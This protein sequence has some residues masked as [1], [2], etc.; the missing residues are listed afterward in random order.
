MIFS[1][2]CNDHSNTDMNCN[3][4]AG[5]R[6]VCS[7]WRRREARRTLGHNVVRSLWWQT[8]LVMISHIRPL[9]KCQASTVDGED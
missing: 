5:I 6:V 7:W 2:C 9:S 3:N 4:L 1:L 8:L